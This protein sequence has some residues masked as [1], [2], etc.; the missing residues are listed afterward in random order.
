MTADSTV[1]PSDPTPRRLLVVTTVPETFH[2]LTSYAR[3]F[4]ARRWRVDG[5]TGD[6]PMGDATRDA[7]DAIHTVSWSRRLADPSNVR[8]LLQVRRVLRRGRYDI[9]HTHTPIASF[10][11][12][13][14][15]ATLRPSGRPRVVYTAHGFHFHP[16]GKRLN[17]LVYAGAETLAGRVTD[18]LVVINEEDRRAAARLRVVAPG[19]LVMMPG[20][21]I[22]LTHYRRT[23]ELLEMAAEWRRSLAIPESAVLFVAVAE[24]TPRKNLA[25]AI[26]ALAL[27]SDAR[28]H[29]CLAGAG[30]LHESLVEQARAL[31]VGDRVHFL[32]S[33]SDVRPLLLSSAALVLPSRQEGLSRAVME[34]LALGVPVVGADTRGIRDLVRPGGGLLVDPDDPAGLSRAFD[35]IQTHDRG[36]AL[37]Q[38]LAG[39][40]GSL[41]LDGLIQR[42]EQLYASL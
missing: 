26:A 39:R 10:V 25:T 40:L 14:A 31:R 9:V 2:F 13:A 21:G 3:H 12:R 35:E 19:R 24:L 16:A 1:A 6:R 30:P 37:T 22:D 4:R 27:N 20:I 42:H 34:S 5:M 11:T 8:A 29:L 33:V 7:F 32:G 36:E 23:P 15:V 41:S 28:L 17:N 38:R 18:R